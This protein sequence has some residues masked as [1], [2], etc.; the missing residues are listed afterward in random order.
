MNNAEVIAV[1]VT[2]RSFLDFLLG[3]D[4]GDILLKNIPVM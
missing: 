4:K 1:V 3:R 2:Y